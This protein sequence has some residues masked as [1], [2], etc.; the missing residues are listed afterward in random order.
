MGQ[1]KQV[2]AIWRRPVHRH[3][4]RAEDHL[5]MRSLLH[6]SRPLRRAGGPRH[7]RPFF[8]DVFE[9]NFDDDNPRGNG[10]GNGNNNQPPPPPPIVTLDTAA[11]DVAGGSTPQQIDIAARIDTQEGAAIG[12]YYGELLFGGANGVAHKNEPGTP[13]KNFTGVQGGREARLSR[14][15]GWGGR[16]KKR[17]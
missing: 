10:G 2:R 16:H 8:D 14:R 3:Q 13:K 4:P 6:N 1:H 12:F 17:G 11:Q 7:I 15:G 9:R 5:T